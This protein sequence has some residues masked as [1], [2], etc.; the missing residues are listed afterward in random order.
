M[1]FT[2]QEQSLFLTDKHLQYLLALQ[3]EMEP[4]KQAT[5]QLFG[6]SQSCLIQILGALK[7]EAIA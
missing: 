6:Q 7:S 4:Q 3:I 1:L 5:I 2:Y